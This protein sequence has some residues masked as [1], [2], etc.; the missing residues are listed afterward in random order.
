MH[1]VAF[2]Q[3]SLR[4]VEYGRGRTTVGST[5]HICKFYAHVAQY[6][7]ALYAKCFYISLVTKNTIV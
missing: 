4:T 3:I 7:S 1:N 2:N 6:H 5:K